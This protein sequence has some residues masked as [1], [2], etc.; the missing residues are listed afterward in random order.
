MGRPPIGKTAMTNTERSRRYRAGL[1]TKPAKK[2][3]DRKI[4]ES[5][6]RNEFLMNCH[7]ATEAAVYTGP[8]DEKILGGC[9]RAAEAWSRLLSRIDP[10]SATKLEPTA[11]KPRKKAKAHFRRLTRW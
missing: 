9:R 11:T 5:N 3:R 4:A 7:M 10:T 6:Y 8:I 2:A 1:A